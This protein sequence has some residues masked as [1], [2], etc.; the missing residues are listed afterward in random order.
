MNKLRVAY[1]SSLRR[2]LKL[3]RAF[4]ASGMFVQ[5]NIPLLVKLTG[6]LI[7]GFT[8]RLNSSCNHIVSALAK[9]SIV[10]ASL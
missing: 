2:L 1:N 10:F 4:S 6:I 9:S 5:Y 7:S 8:N 3:D